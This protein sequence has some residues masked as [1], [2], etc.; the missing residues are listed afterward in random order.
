[1]KNHIHIFIVIAVAT[2]LSSCE[3]VIPIKLDE[4]TS[5]LTVDAFLDDKPGTQKIRLT[6]T[7]AYF[8]NVPNPAA[9]GATVKITDNEGRTYSFVDNA[10]SGDYTWTPLAGDTLLRLFNSYTL[11]IVYSGEEFQATSVAYPAP[12]VDSVTYTPLESA[13]GKSS[14]TAYSASFYA[15]DIAG[16]AN[17]Y[18]IKSYKNGVFYSKPGQMNL[19]QDGAFSGETDGLAFI[20]PIRNSIIPDSVNVNDSV[21]VNIYAIDPETYFFL[22]EVVQQ[23]TNGGLFA[24]PPSNVSTNIKNVTSGST[25]KPVGWFN[26]GAVSTGGVRVK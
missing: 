21:T 24:T 15:Y 7:G 11:S 4:G 17:F 8:D 13:T 22:N 26:I 1:M 25:T 16:M 23:T 5:Q 18:W 19:S 20:Y 14:K 3:K 10:N 12:P 6:K 9:T 2:F